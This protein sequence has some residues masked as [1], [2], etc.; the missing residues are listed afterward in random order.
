MTRILAIDLGTAC[1]YAMG[2]AESGVWD[3][4]NKRHEG[5]GMRFVRFR[6]YLTECLV[7]VDLV[8]YEEVRAHAGVDAAHVYGGLMAI[9]QAECES[10]NLPYKGIPVGTIKKHASGK[11]NAKKDVM[12]ATALTKWPDIKIIDDN[13]ADALWMWDLAMQEWGK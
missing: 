2:L 5:G 1:G 8:F 3:L 7:D 6:K 12:I 4:S 10:R 13:H 11:G 9:L